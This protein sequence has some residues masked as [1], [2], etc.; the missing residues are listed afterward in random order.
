VH[1]NTA[2]VV[3]SRSSGTGLI[4]SQFEDPPIGYDLAIGLGHEHLALLTDDVGCELL[5][6][7]TGFDAKDTHG[8]LD[9]RCD[10]RRR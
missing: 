5:P 10:V 9:R 1:Q 4:G 8:K 6:A 7:I 2:E 3:A